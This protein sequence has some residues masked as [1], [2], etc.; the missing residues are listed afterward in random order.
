CGRGGVGGR[1]LSRCGGGAGC[2]RV[3]GGGGRR[4]FWGG[5][6]GVVLR[7]ACRSTRPGCEGLV[8]GVLWP[9]FAACAAPTV[10]RWRAVLRLLLLFGGWFAVVVATT[11][12]APGGGALFRGGGRVV[13]LFD[14]LAGLGINPRQ[15]LGQAQSLAHIAVELPCI[16]LRFIMGL[17]DDGQLLP[18]LA[19]FAVELLQLVRAATAGP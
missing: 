11:A 4:S 17:S 18:E 1:F 15:S 10:Q 6:P 19:Q 8:R 12:G 5:V 7:W 2:C 3:G 16:A 13:A 9:P 14:G